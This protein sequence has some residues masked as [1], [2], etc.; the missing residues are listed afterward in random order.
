M[1]AR[2]GETSF[3][4][5]EPD[6]YKVSTVWLVS[7]YGVT[8]SDLL[9][10]PMG[11][12]LVSKVAPFRRRGMMMGGWFGATAVGTKL[13]AIS[14]YWRRWPHSAFFVVL[15]LMCVAVGEFLPFCSSRS[16]R[17]CPG[18]EVNRL[19]CRPRTA[20]QLQISYKSASLPLGSEQIR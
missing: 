13:T 6:A 7:S 19:P 10:T 15:G 18:S 9:L 20:R 11:L 12:S 17:P 2:L 14:V 16:S 4:G 1:A 5:L 8:L 3:T